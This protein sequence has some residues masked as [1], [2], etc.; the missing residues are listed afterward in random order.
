MDFSDIYFTENLI[1][2]NYKI[3]RINKYLIV[4]TFGYTINNRRIRAKIL[5]SFSRLISITMFYLLFNND[6]IVKPRLYSLAREKSIYNGR[7][8]FHKLTY[9]LIKFD[10]SFPLDF[11]SLFFKFLIT[12]DIEYMKV[13]FEHVER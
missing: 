3:V 1:K 4:Q 13:V 8:L 9:K 7:R 6:M 2:S 5:G 10:V 12:G 11:L